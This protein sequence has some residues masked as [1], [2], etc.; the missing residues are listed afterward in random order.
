MVRLSE[1]CEL[2]FEPNLL[3]KE[4][5]NALLEIAVVNDE[6]PSGIYRLVLKLVDRQEESI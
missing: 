6:N 1:D 5:D 2:A 3:S 4:R